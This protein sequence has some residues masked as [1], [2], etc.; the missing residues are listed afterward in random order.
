MSTDSQAAGA[1]RSPDAFVLRSAAASV[2]T[3]SLWG[4]VVMIFW[5]VPLSAVLPESIDPGWI[6][7]GV[8]LVAV[9]C[10][11]ASRI[12]LFVDDA[13]VRAR[14]LFRTYCARWDEMFEISAYGAAGTPMGT[15]VRFSLDRCGWRSGWRKVITPQATLSFGAEEAKRECLELLRRKAREHGILFQLALDR[16]EFVVPP[17]AVPVRDRAEA[18]EFLAARQPPNG[19]SSSKAMRQ[20]A[21][22]HGMVVLSLALGPPVIVLTIVDPGSFNNIG[23]PVFI[24]L[25][26]GFAGVAWDQRDARRKPQ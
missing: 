3:G 24:A 12:G 5:A 10:W 11:R 20:P 23:L 6:P 8:L 17:N 18:S 21:S 1:G 13:G 2:V 22:F 9:V 7:T 14:N 15:S 4:T 19:R 26:L 25:A 16:I